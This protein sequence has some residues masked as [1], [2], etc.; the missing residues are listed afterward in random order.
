MVS[1]A[2]RPVE[3]AKAF[4]CRIL[5]LNLGKRRAASLQLC[6]LMLELNADYALVQEPLF[7]TFG[8]EVVHVAA[9]GKLVTCAVKSPKCRALILH[10]PSSS[11]VFLEHLFTPDCAVVSALLNNLPC[12]LVSAYF[13]CTRDIERDLSVL[14]QIVAAAPGGRV[15]IHADSNARS[16][17]WFDNIQNSRGKKLVS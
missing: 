8:E 1:P 6:Q 15:L 17:L 2:S 4:G 10:R 7:R 16:T 3:A 12:L 9:S 14:D 11:A 5:G 13:D